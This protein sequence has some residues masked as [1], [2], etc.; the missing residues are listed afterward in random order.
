M[1]KTVVVKDQF[2]D[3]YD[4]P[5]EN[6]QQ[7]MAAGYSQA[8][9]EDLAAEA[10][11]ER[12]GGTS[13]ELKAAGLG[14]LSGATFGLGTLALTKTGILSPE[15]A[16]GYRE[17]NPD[18]YTT[19]EVGGAI[20]SM[21]IPGPNLV[22]G[23]DL[24]RKGLTA[25][26]LKALPEATTLGGKVAQR[27]AAGAM[28]SAVEGA[29][30]GAGTLINDHALG[31][32]DLNAEKV[33][34]TLG[35]SAAF[36]GAIGAVLGPVEAA[37]AKK[38]GGIVSEL[39]AAAPAN[40]AANL[41][42]AVDDVNLVAPERKQG[43][44]DGLKEL[45]PNSKEIESAAAEIGAP[46]LEGQISASKHIQK[47]ESTLMQS[48]SPI[49][50]ARQQM[51]QQGFDAAET[52]LKD[53]V[54]TGNMM[55]RAD[56]G[57]ALKESLTTK[58]EAQAK[59]I[60][61]LYETIKQSTDHIPVS[62]RAKSMI[63]T[64][65]GKMED[66]KF[67]GSMAQ[68]IGDKAMGFLDSIK[69]VDDIKRA[70]TILRQDIPATAPVGE[71]AAVER[72]IEKLT[73]LEENTIIREAERMA[74]EAADPALRDNILSL[75]K[76]RETA[77]SAYKVLREKMGDVA[78]V[79]GKKRVGG[80]GDFV[81]FVDDLTPEKLA[82]KLFAKKNSEFLKRFATEFPEETKLLFDF[83]K[84]KFLTKAMRGENLDPKA[85]VKELTKFEKDYPEIYN[86]MF[87]KEQ[88]TKIKAAKTYLDSLPE[89]F[90]PSGTPEALEYRKYF[91]DVFDAGRDIAA[92]AGAGAAMG[93]PLGALVGG[94]VGA[95][96]TQRT[97]L[98]DYGIE[99]LIQ[100]TVRGGEGSPELLMGKLSTIERTINKTTN[101]IDRLSRK[102][103]EVSGKTVDALPGA[104]ILM[105][106]EEREK[107]Y[108][109]VKEQIE[110]T[111]SPDTYLEKVENST[112]AMYDAAPTITGSMQMA[113]TRA[114]E[115]LRTKLPAPGA[116]APLSNPLK[117]SNAE[118]SKFLRYYEVVENPVIVLNQIKTGMLTTESMETMKTVYP[119]LLAEMRT[120]VIDKITNKKAQD[121][122]YQTKVM[123]SFF[124][125]QD[126]VYGVA[127]NSIMSNQTS[128]A[129]PSAKQDDIQTAIAQQKPSQKGLQSL[130]L[131]ERS[132]TGTEKVI[133]RT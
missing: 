45:K 107:K 87:S 3:L 25:A 65:I 91:T 41:R 20:G 37:L 113:M 16:A 76:D 38:A 117:P 52:A 62:Q 121:I 109:K 85:L 110:E 78:E 27:A 120:A 9:K 89:K 68:K 71:R 10:K 129:G 61:Q 104:V 6:L 101:A 96:G 22:K 77:N 31:D 90:G 60:S 15:D 11:A 131:S 57:N 95:L 92:G 86:L 36:G 33:M 59:P 99:K 103:I 126:L 130:T 133:N 118:I 88:A 53:A 124:L 48:P 28:G 4:M 8:T 128:F 30:Y 82:D 81:N 7:A 58:F 108:E 54:G 111:N 73:D 115:F 127:S 18:A 12:Y 29:F 83:E 100:A 39:D 5:A 97:L 132:Q 26:A 56:I 2:G 105:N 34:S 102:V 47:L 67:T 17:V 24:A 75:I 72:V 35:Y 106:Q 112:K 43:I 49:G 44:L 40:P 66:Y 21:L 63:K 23:A 14:A 13:G 80:V 94:A 50:I 55:S 84:D 1:A 114:T 51:A 98:R 125:E 69:T 70:K 19:G 123:L 93:G 119:G 116:Y 46:L 42:M 122:P 32:P 74:K 79:L 64:N